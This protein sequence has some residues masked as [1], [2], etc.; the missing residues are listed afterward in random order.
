VWLEGADVFMNCNKE[1]KMEH[2]SQT[3]TET[4]LL[5]ISKVSR[6]DSQYKFTSLA[7]LLDEE[8]LAKCYTCLKNTK[9]SGVDEISVREYGE[10]LEDNL[11]A[12]IERMN[13][14]S[15][16]SGIIEEGKIMKSEQGTP[17]GGNISPILANIY[18]HYIL[19]IWFKFR[20]K[21]GLDGYAEIVR[22]ADDFVIVVEK[23][24]DCEK[25]LKELKERLSKFGL[26]LSETKTKVIR[27]GRNGSKNNPT[28]TFDFLGFTHY[29]CKSRQG[30]LMLSRK[31][32][33]T[34][35]SRKLKEI[36]EYLR[37]NR[38]RK[39]LP[40]LWKIIN[41]KLIVHY[42]YYGI[43]GNSRSIGNYYDKVK[44]IVFKWLNRR[45]QRQSFNWQNY[46]KYLRSFALPKPRIYVNLYT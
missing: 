20:L 19:D 43:S 11:R 26:E 25:I 35:F 14:K 23:Q 15:Y 17:Q 8:Y 42:R 1:T 13:R 34:R 21:K 30:K 40:E 37:F 41:S 24:M 4:K 31:T 33:K 27:F 16:K 5:Q 44:I 22:Y 39:K 36:N 29:I 2:R 46:N 10:H 9:A 12:L 28:G 32:S 6:A 3:K 45:S 7:S 18:L 38:N